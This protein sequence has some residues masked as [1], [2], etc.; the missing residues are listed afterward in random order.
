M[1]LVAAAPGI[2]A[3]TD[4]SVSLTATLDGRP[5]PLKDV[6]KYD[7]D[8]FAYPVITCSTSAAGLQ[9]RASVAVSAGLDYVTIYDYVSFQGSFMNVSQDYSSLL[10]IGW[11]DRI[12]SFKVRNS[13]TGQFFTDWFYGGS[14][15]PFCCNTQQSSLGAYDNTFSSVQRT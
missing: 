11:S 2:T 4:G 8:D 7:C 13:E 3:A 14:S 15:W 6:A 9:A 12:S 5:I 10:T 1:A